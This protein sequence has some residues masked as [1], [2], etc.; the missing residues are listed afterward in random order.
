MAKHV[1]R[2][3]TPAEAARVSRDMKLLAR[4][5]PALLARGQRM[6]ERRQHLRHAVKALK[7]ER[8]AQ[9]ISLGELAKRTQIAKATLSKLENN[10]AANPTVATLT[11]IAAAL[12][13]QITIDLMPAA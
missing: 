4:E 8:L 5:Q 6:L 13:R 1:H 9:G 3:L 10:M 7:A 11:R 12:G 2:K